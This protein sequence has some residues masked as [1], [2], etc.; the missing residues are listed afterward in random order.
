MVA[1]EGKQLNSSMPRRLLRGMSF[2]HASPPRTITAWILV[3]LY[4]AGIFVLSSLSQPP[5]ASTWELPHLDKLYHSLEYGG[6]TLLL[7]RAL[8]LTYPACPLTALCVWG[9]VLA[10]SHGALDEW[11]QAFTPGRMM[12]LL[13]VFADAAG[14][15]AVA[16]MWPSMERRWLTLLGKKD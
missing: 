13:D 5:L 14:A 1:Q 11:H 10:V 9:L 16:G 12:S 8:R 3:G 7:M 6:L 4:A 2:S 15:S